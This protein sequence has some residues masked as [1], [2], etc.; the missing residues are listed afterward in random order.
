M[1]AVSSLKKATD[2]TA[3]QLYRKSNL[4]QALDDISVVEDEK[5]KAFVLGFYYGISHSV[6]LLKKID[7]LELEVEVLH[8]EIADMEDENDE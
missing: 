3:A 1:R 8:K 5:I 4:E 2:E 6:N 7:D